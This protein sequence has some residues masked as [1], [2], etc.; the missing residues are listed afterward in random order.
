MTAT[1]GTCKSKRASEHQP[2]VDTLVR[3]HAKAKHICEEAEIRTDEE[4]CY[5]SRRQ[6]PGSKTG[7]CEGR[8]SKAE[9]KS[10]DRDVDRLEE[11]TAP[12]PR[13]EELRTAEKARIRE[14]LGRKERGP[15]LQRR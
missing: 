10:V 1:T 12:S 4:N 11:G 3:A 14:V 5:I 2:W 15:F 9:T 13:T 8:S 6:I 7:F